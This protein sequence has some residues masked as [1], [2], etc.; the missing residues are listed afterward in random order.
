MLK[1][2]IDGKGACRIFAVL[3]YLRLKSGSFQVLKEATLENARTSVKETGV[4]RFDVIQQCND[5]AR[6][7]LLEMVRSDTA[8]AE[9]KKTK[10]HKKGRETVADMMAE[11]RCGVK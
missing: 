7:V 3:V 4:A 5:P 2:S 1:S 6:F 8:P 10:H 9:H 11:D